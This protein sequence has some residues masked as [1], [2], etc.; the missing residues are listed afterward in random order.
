MAV[1]KG[2]ETCTDSV[3]EHV[4]DYTARDTATP[5][6]RQHPKVRCR[7]KTVMVLTTS[8]SNGRPAC[9]ILPRTLR[10]DEKR[11]CVCDDS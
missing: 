9:P 10:R 2:S 11:P 7:S 8:G 3:A 5:H 6:A 1:G 4:T